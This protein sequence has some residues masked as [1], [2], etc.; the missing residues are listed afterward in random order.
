MLVFVVVVAFLI[1]LIMPSIWEILH[2]SFPRL[3]EQNPVFIL[4]MVLSLVG[5]LIFTVY[6][7]KKGGKR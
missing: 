5:A 1:N 6:E 4:L 7:K 3:V 2:V